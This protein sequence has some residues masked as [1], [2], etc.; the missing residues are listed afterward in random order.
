MFSIS[1]IQQ[2]TR[3]IKAERIVLHWLIYNPKK[4]YEETIRQEYFSTETHKIIFKQIEDDILLNKPIDV[5]ILS[6][7]LE[8]KIENPKYVLTIDKD[9]E[10]FRDFRSA[11]KILKNLYVLRNVYIKGLELFDKLNDV[12][13]TDETSIKEIEGLMMRN[14]MQFTDIDEVDLKEISSK[15]IEIA[16]QK[17]N[18]KYHY[19]V[20]SSFESLFKYTNGFIP[21]LYIV[22]GRPAMGKTSFVNT[23]ALDMAKNGT[24]VGVFYL[25]T[26]A[27]ENIRRMLSMES[28]IELNKIHSGNLTNEEL[29]KLEITKDYISSLPL[30]IIDSNT[31]DIMDLI[32]EIKIM[33][34]RH[35]IDIVFI[36][37]LTHI[38]NSKTFDNKTYE[39]EDTVRRLSDLKKEIE[40]PII[41]MHQLNREIYKRNKYRPTLAELKSSGGIEQE[42]D[43]VMLLHRPAYY[44]E[45]DEIAPDEEG[46]AEW[47]V[48]KNREGKTGTIK[49]GWLDT[50]TQ[51]INIPDF[52]EYF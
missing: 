6:K 34:M 26:T 18:G 44:K 13:P 14:I 2:K 21:G 7:E 39:I 37:Q 49:V 25:E 27:M 35:D 23:L 38:R 8:G 45:P 17:M 50:F 46:V 29:E 48:A 42:A 52:E 32:K 12:N 5:F 9:L 20:K 15:A 16:I 11:V 43:F 10:G 33:K 36:D 4:Y 24:K 30:H 31:M 22:A 41:L 40:I 1:E 3:D 47:I 28:K 51:F 19:P